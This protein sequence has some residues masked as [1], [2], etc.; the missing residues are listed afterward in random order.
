ME[1]S[2]QDS[3][4]LGTLQA[5]KQ[6]DANTTVYMD[7]MKNHCCYDAIPTSCK[8]VIFDTKLQVQ[9][10]F[11]ALVANSLRA[12]P[13][14]DSK[15]KRFVGMLTITDFI[16]IVHCYYKS[17]LVQMYELEN[18]KIET[19]RDVYLKSSRPF[20]ISISPEAR[21][22]RCPSPHSPGDPSWRA[23]SGPSRTWPPFARPPR[24]T[25]PSTS[26]WIAGCRR[27]RWWMKKAKWWPSTP[28]LTSSIWRPR[29]RTT[30]W[31]SPYWRLSVSAAVPLRASSSATPTRLWRP[32]LNASSL[33]RF[34]DWSWWTGPTWS[35]ASS[36]CPTFFR[37]WS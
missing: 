5:Q 37:P 30:T 7:F 23:A 3:L 8:L 24:F 36:P 22:R 25:T 13:L 33:P 20:L 26:L 14:W 29:R 19:W 21:G 31:T 2:S 6:D 18:H 17:P 1:A 10:A 27:S 28:D 11:F 16:N 9:K 15:L 4:Q 12:A 32:S 35:R 34:T